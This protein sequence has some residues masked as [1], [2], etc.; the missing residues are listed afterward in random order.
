MRNSYICIHQP[1]NLPDSWRK[2]TEV[3]NTTTIN[4]MVPATGS[5]MSLTNGTW[6]DPTINKSVSTSHLTPWICDVDSARLTP[7]LQGPCQA[8]KGWGNR[9]KLEAVNMNSSCKTRLLDPGSKG[10]WDE[11]CPL[12]HSVCHWQSCVM[13]GMASFWCRSKRIHQTRADV[14]V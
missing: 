9:Q 2:M 8:T 14:K 6:M 4:Q 11:C 13:L 5:K 3:Q 12:Q 7:N 10:M 1:W